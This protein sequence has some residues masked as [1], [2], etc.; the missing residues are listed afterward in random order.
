MLGDSLN[1][2]SGVGGACVV[3]GVLAVAFGSSGSRGKQQEEDV[4]GDDGST[5]EQ[6]VFD[7]KEVRWWLVGWLG[8]WLS[9][10]WLV[11]CS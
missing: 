6:L 3:G 8:R 1:W 2:M 5:R 11:S 10:G 4:D 9:S 7:S